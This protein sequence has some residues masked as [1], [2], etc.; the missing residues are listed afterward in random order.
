MHEEKAKLPPLTSP[1]ISLTEVSNRYTPDAKVRKDLPNRD[2]LPYLSPHVEGHT[3]ICFC[4]FS[5]QQSHI[6]H[7]NLQLAFYQIIHH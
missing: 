5:L 7:M 4:S 2:V 1:T 6:I 3:V